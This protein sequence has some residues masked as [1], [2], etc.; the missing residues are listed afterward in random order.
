MSLTPEQAWQAAL[1]QLQMEMPKSSFDAWVRDSCLVS[2]QDGQFVIGVRN[3]Y[4]REWLDAR[5]SSTVNRLLMGMMNQEVSVQ[6][7]VTEAEPPAEDEQLPDHDSRPEDE[8]LVEAHYDLAYD[9]I[10]VPEHITL[11]PRYFLRHL[12]RIG[13]DLGWLY[14]GF[15]QAAFNAGARSGNKRERFTG[16]AIAALSGIAERTLWNKVGSADTWERLQGLV[17]TTHAAPE[18]DTG[19]ASPRRL[20]RRYVVAMSL[21]LTAEDAHSLRAFLTD[22]LSRMGKPEPLIQAAILLPL[23]TLLPPDAMS[24]EGDKPESVTSILHSLFGRSIPA[25]RLAALA[26][27]LHKHIMP[28]NDRL[29]VT[30]FFVEHILPYLGTG[31]GWMLTLLRDHCYVNRET[32]EVRDQVRIVGGYAEIASWMGV[33]PE[34]V[35]RWLHGKHSASRGRSKAVEKGGQK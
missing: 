5:L 31:P 16:K 7:I 14:M 2:Y 17:T 19:S 8:L 3:V 18:W 1:G 21:P 26:T 25:E 10:V 29:A 33:T 24:R 30:H 27:Q 23:D 15:R 20:P 34:T 32:G 12:R 11:V 35:W 6:F 9:E 13:P 22:N 28:D 4:A